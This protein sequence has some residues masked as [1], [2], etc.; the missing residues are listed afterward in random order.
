M[1]EVTRIW[2]DLIGR[3]SGPLTMRLIL[4]PVMASLYAVRDGL[5]DAQAG[6]PPYLW[7]IFSHP[8]ERRRLI[9]DGWKSIGKIIALAIILDVVYQLIVFRR[10]YPFESIDVAIILAVLPYSLLRGPV[11]RIARLWKLA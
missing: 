4:Q 11:N 5:K 7:T 6:R 2:T 1:D 3:L 9:R 10:I 8:E